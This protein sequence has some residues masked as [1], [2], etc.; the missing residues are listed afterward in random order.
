MPTQTVVM[1]T[2]R[3]TSLGSSIAPP[4]PTWCST[5]SWI[6]ASSNPTTFLQHRNSTEG[7]QGYTISYAGQLALAGPVERI[8]SQLLKR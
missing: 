5:V 2:A 3:R 8:L 4:S 1:T 6:V 7:D